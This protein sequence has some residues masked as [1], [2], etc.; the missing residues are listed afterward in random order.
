MLRVAVL[1]VTGLLAS[2]PVP[3]AAQARA[4]VMVGIGDQKTQMFHD[5]RFGRLGIHIARYQ[6]AWDAL[7]HPAQRA[8][9]DEWLFAAR[10][11]GVRPLITFGHART[12]R[13]YHVLPTV[14]RFSYEFSLFHRRYPWVKDFATWNEANYCGEPTCHHPAI[15]ARYW[16][17]IRRQCHGCNVLAAELL[18]FPNMVSWVREF[19]RA[20]RMEPRIWGMHNYRDTN[21]LTT[22]N[23]RALLGAMRGRLWL[24]ETGGIVYRRNRSRVSF[25]QSARHA[26]IATRWLFN[27]IV[28]LSGR[29]TRVY[30]YEWNAVQVHATWDTALI[31]ADGRVRP[32]FGV[33]ERVVA[34]GRRR[35]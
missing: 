5:P 32:A 23:T 26:A 25:P 8:E 7:E 2:L 15:V 3:A 30:L 11:A 13:G 6:M 20:A 18:D 14:G 19:R 1:A 29:I 21:R 34:A 16:R 24:T 31:G 22:G 4:P 33:L 12:T 35:R 17:A 27:R 28:P 9:V 10:L